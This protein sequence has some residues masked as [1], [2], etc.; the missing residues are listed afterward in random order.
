MTAVEVKSLISEYGF[1]TISA[2]AVFF[3]VRYVSR[4][5]KK[6]DGFKEDF[7]LIHAKIEGNG[8][9]LSEKVDKIQATAQGTHDRS[10]S[11]QAK[12]LELYQQLSQQMNEISRGVSS[13]DIAMQKN[14]RQNFDAIK[15]IVV[16]FKEMQGK[17]QSHDKSLILS[18]E[19]FRRL[20][21]RLNDLE[22]KVNG[23]GPSKESTHAGK[24]D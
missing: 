18:S 2:I 15:D 16:E 13:M 21:K 17:V 10:I 9:T 14:T 6:F 1:Q 22:V 3:L 7:K 19:A 24:N 4:T 12:A 23:T 8:K 5:D 11:V 20:V